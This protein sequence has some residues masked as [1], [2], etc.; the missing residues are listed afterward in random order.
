MKFERQT[1]YCVDMDDYDVTYKLRVE[2]N[3]KKHA[4]ACVDLV[5]NTVERVETDTSYLHLTADDCRDMA[6]ALMMFADEADR[7]NREQR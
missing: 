7:Y 2:Y 5:V 1:N 4:P 3:D 6:K